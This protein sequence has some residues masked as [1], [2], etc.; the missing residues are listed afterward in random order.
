MTSRT[1]PWRS[2]L[3]H[4][5]NPEQRL[6]ELFWS[7]EQPQ[8]TTQR[9]EFLIASLGDL[10]PPVR[11]AAALRLAQDPPQEHTRQE[12]TAHL[13]KSLETKEDKITSSG[14]T[15]PFM[16]PANTETGLA[17]LAALKGCEDPPLP[18]LLTK[19]TTHTNP[20]VRYQAL[21][22]LFELPPSAHPQ[23]LGSILTECLSD[24]DEE[25]SI[26]AAQFISECN[27][28]ELLPEL[29]KR[30]Q[31][32]SRK[33][34]ASLH[35]T[36]SITHLLTT[37]SEDQ[38][39]DYAYIIESLKKE[40]IEGIQHE[41]S[42]SASSSALVDLA[43]MLGQKEL[44]CAPL[45]KVLNRWFLHPLLKVEA[46]AQL[47]R[48]GDAQGLNYLSTMLDGKRKDTR[49]HAISVAGSLRI[50][51]LYGQV[52]RIAQSPQDYHNDT[53]ILAMANY[54]TPQAR[55]HLKQ[56]AESHADEE[57]RTLAKQALNTPKVS[58]PLTFFSIHQ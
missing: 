43:L 2:P 12:L 36:L 24:P 3:A 21:L 15:P 57:L 11:Q 7:I 44:A 54:A 38:R 40:L 13:S 1:P 27:L 10:Y 51:P 47:T 39:A 18:S 58:K 25:V 50:E 42:S 30:H 56:L 37:A 20:D 9:H 48:L 28:H 41:V 19:L 16:P 55:E 34:A 49:G 26:I 46:A 23:N 31:Q 29:I 8:S 14:V 33:Q 22:N 17:I 35:I 52:A 6:Q 32:L 53:A 5:A 4:I 45:R